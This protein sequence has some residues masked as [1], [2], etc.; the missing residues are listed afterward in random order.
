[1]NASTALSDAGR[2]GLVALWPWLLLVGITLA[3]CLLTSDAADGHMTTTVVILLAAFKIRMV[4]IHFMEVPWAAHPWR[5]VLELW[6][7]L[8]TTIILGGYWWSVSS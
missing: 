5:I 7:V 2:P 3:G 1:M 6:L 8:V 4:I